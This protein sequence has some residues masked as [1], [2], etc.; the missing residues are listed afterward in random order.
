MAEVRQPNEIIEFMIYK[1]HPNDI[2]HI[3]YT[4]FLSGGLLCDSSNSGDFLAQESLAL[5]ERL[6]EDLLKSAESG[7]AERGE[8]R[9]WFCKGE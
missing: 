1:I 8:L 6:L 3:I 4:A 5:V 7:S 9:R 2:L